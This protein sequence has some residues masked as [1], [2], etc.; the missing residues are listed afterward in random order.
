VLYICAFQDWT[1]APPFAQLFTDDLAAVDAF[2]KKHDVPGVSVYECVSELKPGSRRRCLDT[3]AAS[4]SLYVDIDLRDLVTAPDAVLKKLQQLHQTLPFEIRDS[5]GGYHIAV[6]LKERAEID[7]PYYNR[8]IIARTALTEM[9]CADPAP[10]HSAA[11]LRRLGTHNSKW[12]EARECRII[13]PGAP[14]DITDLEAFIE[15]YGGQPQFKRKPKTNGGARNIAEA[16]SEGRFNRENRI[17]NL[18][19]PGNIHLYERDCTASLISSGV[20]L[21]NTVAT[22]FDDVKTYI[23]GHPPQQPWNWDK[24]KRR[25]TRLAYTWINKHPELA[26][27]LPADLLVEYNRILQA[28]GTPLLYWSRERKKWW[29]K[30]KTPISTAAARAKI[31]GWQYYGSTPPEPMRWAIKGIL[32]ERGVTV[33][34][35]QWGT[36]KTT[37]AL[38]LALSIMTGVLFAGRY[39]VKKPG[40]VIYFAPEGN[41]GIEYRLKALAEAAEITD[42]LP[43]A[44]RPDC[45]PLKDKKSVAPINALIDEA[46]AELKRTHNVDTVYAMFDT[47]AK[48]AGTEAKGEDDDSAITAT[49]IKTLDAIGEHSECGTLIVDHMGKNI[50]AGTRGSSGKEAVEGLLATLGDRKMAEPITNTRLVI[51]KVKDGRAG[52]ELPFTP[53]T[54]ETGQDEDGDP[55]TAILIDWGIPQDCPIKA[56]PE[57]TGTALL[58]SRME[59]LMATEGKL[60]DR[61]SGRVMAVPLDR[62]REKFLADF[63]PSRR[64]RGDLTEGQRL[65]TAQRTFRRAFTDA[66]RAG[67]VGYRKTNGVTWIWWVQ[68]KG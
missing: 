26:P 4:A 34:S 63:K 55:I 28:D 65:E 44:H 49:V 7:T 9:L 25:I 46:A 36:F 37:V 5:G 38:S 1:D 31:S 67:L 21:D 43:F 30:S 59:G 53:H 22:V 64:R 14:V 50:E 20:D 18:C 41:G 2:A 35:G 15:L 54:I 48:A 3:V 45:P 24:E 13:Q 40:G 60:L 47:W 17:A 58:Q 32:I 11:L 56:P 42:V 8:A 16:D 68:G 23:D 10:N 19:Y 27:T 51:R 12:G 61:K 29:V 33:L 57:S 62:V 66:T 39:R 6:H 52:F